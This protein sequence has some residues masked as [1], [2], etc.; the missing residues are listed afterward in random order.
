[1]FGRAIFDLGATK[2]TTVPEG[3]IIERGQLRQVLVAEDGIARA[4]LITAGAARDGRQEVLSGLN[5][6]ERVVFPIPAGLADGDK[7]EVRP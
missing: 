1:M 3:A 5:P 7:V 6:G 4:R 2:A